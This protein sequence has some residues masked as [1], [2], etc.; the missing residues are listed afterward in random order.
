MNIS[1]KQQYQGLRIGILGLICAQLLFWG[2]RLFDPSEILGSS[3]L[4]TNYLALILVAVVMVIFG[5]IL[6]VLIKH[7]KMIDILEGYVLIG[8][9]ICLTI[10]FYTYLLFS[11]GFWDSYLNQMAWFIRLNGIY[12]GIM[13]SGFG[14]AGLVLLVRLFPYL[15][16]MT[17]S[18]RTLFCSGIIGVFSFNVAIMNII[19]Q[20]QGLLGIFLYTLVYLFISGVYWLFLYQKGA[21][22][23]IIPES[24]S[25][26]KL[27]QGTINKGKNPLGISV[28]ILHFI[29]TNLVLIA[30]IVVILI[31]LGSLAFSFSPI[32]YMPQ[33]H[34][35]FFFWGIFGAFIAFL[36][37]KSQRSINIAEIIGSM[38]IL[39]FIFLLNWDLVNNAF[40]YVGG[41]FDVIFPFHILLSPLHAAVMGTVTGLFLAV[42]MCRLF[43]HYELWATPVIRSFLVLA[44]FLGLGYIIG[45]NGIFNAFGGEVFWWSDYR[46]EKGMLI[47]SEPLIGRLGGIATYII[48]FFSLVIIIDGL[49]FLIKS[50]LSGKKLTEIKSRV[51]YGFKGPNFTKSVESFSEKD[52]PSS[53][54]P[55][56]KQIW[57][58]GLIIA[59][60]LPSFFIVVS[61][62][63][64]QDAFRLPLVASGQGYNV[65]AASSYIRINPEQWILPLNQK[66]TD[67]FSSYTLRMARNEY[68]SFQLILSS[69]TRSFNGL[70]YSISNFNHTV[71]NE[72]ISASAISVRYAETVILNQYYDRLIP[73]TQINLL[74][75][76]NHMIWITA[77]APY[78][79]SPGR[80]SGLINFTFG[81]YESFAITLHLD[82]WNFTMPNYR[83]IRSNFGG[84][85][86]NPEAIA[87]YSSHRINS[88]GISIRR[89]G[90]LYELA[91]VSGFTCYLNETTNQW[92]FNWTWWD[93]QI[94]NLLAGGTNA[95]W[96]DHPLGMPRDPPFW[97]ST[98]N[99]TTKWGIQYG[100]FLA[101][102]D[103]HFQDK[104]VNES[105]N[106]Y[107][108]GYIYFIDEFQMV[109]PEGFERQD[110]FRYLEGF[111]ALI[112]ASAP[113]IPI[114]TT[115]PPSRELLHIRAYIDIYCPITSDYNKEEWQAAQ[116]EGK[117]MWMYPCIGPTSPWPNSHLY[118]RLYEIRVLYWQAWLYNLDGFLYW[119]AQA[120]YHGSYGFGYNAWGDGWFLYEDTE[121]HIYDSIRWE[122]WR[123]ANEDFEYLWL[124][125][126][127]IAVTGNLAEDQSKLTQLVDM[128]TGTR[129]NYCDSGKI[130]IFAR[131]EIGGWLN[132]RSNQVDL[133]NL[134]EF[135]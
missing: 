68:E 74:E 31:G 81:P 3:T 42:E 114:M 120:Y 87:T 41:N 30:R 101:G 127:T 2:S 92:A 76:Q 61:G 5:G 8:A 97:N 118:N 103:A 9:I 131:N 58:L 22:W 125:N 50:Q 113:N 16:Q 84:Q 13:L 100:N 54:I 40:A 59:L 69:Q 93:A 56:K 18:N 11:D 108:Y 98:T 102:L 83:H 52:F 85:T 49:V 15:H 104:L 115:T 45:E 34:Q 128:V 60:F 33:F 51:L 88:Y 64:T 57:A 14:M 25:V 119:S 99:T 94:E 12:V 121:G 122:N 123:D 82:I 27:L 4:N 111:L 6:V 106:W 130:V 79:C 134:A 116:A 55:S 124:M 105:K 135:S 19:F 26:L 72:S 48:I 37:R 80:Y 10:T 89:A 75:S 36:V 35:R 109:I 46:N 65:F 21:V 28:G 110:Y 39:L 117:E 86:T 112:N 29:I 47:P 63:K 24:E 78:T 96:L 133:V 23:G 66:N 91:N 20:I 1:F 90:T 132:S 44:V 7:Q 95:F 38:I 32:Y 71:S 43:T 17:V 77:H 62:S 73:F 129:Y 107:Q 126:R 67:D 53:L 70:R